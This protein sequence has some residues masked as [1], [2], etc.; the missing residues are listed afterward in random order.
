[1]AI[2]AYKA[3]DAASEFRHG[4]LTADTAAEARRRLR[5]GG[6]RILELKTAVSA[7]WRTLWPAR[8]RGQDLVAETA[9]NLSLLLAAGVPLTEGLDVLVQQASGN[10]EAVLRRARERIA[11]GMSLADAL[12]D[13][14]RYF[15][16]VFLSAVRVGEASGNLDQALGELAGYLRERQDLQAKLVT[17][18]IYP[19]ILAVLS[20]FVVIFLMTFVI[21]QLLEVLT[22]AGKSLPASTQ[23]LKTLSDLIVKHWLWLLVGGMALAGV[24][25]ATVRSRK[26]R[27]LWHNVKLRL[28]LLGVLTRK[29]LTAQFAQIMSLLLRSGVPFVKAVGVARQSI[30]NEVLARELESVQRAV[31]A[32]S[33]IAPALT[34]SRIFPPLVVHLVS[35]GQ[36]T[37]ELEHMMEQLRHG[38]ENEVRLAIARFTAALEPVLIIILAS[39]VGF[40]VFATMMP[41]LQAT[42]VIG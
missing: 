7:R 38:Y 40:V 10:F 27:H 25:T 26:G 18:L 24:F 4:T 8:R 22:A 33:D 15:N 42:R 12:A 34:G 19:L 31:E 20:T 39:V 35:V 28:P 21:P 29:T 6:L 1:M 23:L 3:L 5:A 17:A 32:G 11:E 2:F 9:R 14:P 13:H 30:P 37:G 41:I 36:N 16:E